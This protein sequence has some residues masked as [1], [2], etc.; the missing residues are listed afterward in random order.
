MLHSDLS[1]HRAEK[2]CGVKCLSTNTDSLH[3]KINEIEPFL[4]IHDIEIAAF[5]ETLPKNSTTEEYKN[6]TLNINGYTC[7]SNFGGRGA[8][9]YISKEFEVIQRYEEHENIFSPSIFCKIKTKSGEMLTIGV[10]YRSPNSSKQE[11]ENF[12]MQLNKVCEKFNTI[13]Q[14]LVLMG[15]FNCPEI[16]WSEET[17]NK[18]S[19][20]IAAKLLD[21]IHLNY[22][23][24]FVDRPTHHRAMQNSTLIDLILSNDPEIV[25]HIKHFPPFGKSHH[26]ALCFSLGLKSSNKDTSHVT[27]YAVNKGDYVNMKEHM[28]GINWVTLLDNQEEVDIMWDRFEAEINKAKELFIP[29]KKFKNSNKHIFQAGSTPLQKLHLKRAAFKTFKK[30][31]TP[32]NYH[33]YTRYRNQ[34]KC[35]ARKAKC[36]KE[37]EVAQFSKSNPKLFF[38][39][40]NSKI[41]PKENISNLLKEDGSLTEGDLEKSEILNNF[42][43]S[44]FTKENT[45]DMPLFICENEVITS[46]VSISMKD[47]EK[48]LLSL[49]TCK[50]PGPDEIHPRILKELAHELSLPLK[51]LFDKTVS[52]GHLPHKWKEAEVRPIYKKGSKTDPGNYRPV[53]LTSVVCKVFEGFVR[54]KIYDHLVDNNLLSDEQYGFC[55]GRS[56]TTQ[57]LN[58]MQD[59]LRQLDN[60]TPVDAVYLDFKK[61]FDTVPHKRLIS[62]LH[63]YGIRGK[64]LDWIKDFLTNR[65]QYVTINKDSSSKIPVT[66]GVPQ[67]SVLGPT[68]F[69]Y[70]INDLP[71]VASSSLK[72]FADDTKAYLPITSTEDKDNLQNTID[73]LV[74]WSNTWL[75]KF[76]SSKCKV[77]HIGKKN[78]KYSYNIREEN[79]LQKL[80]E[81]T[82]EKDLG[83]MVDPLLHFDTHVTGIV[84]RARSLSGLIHKTI[85]FKNKD[86]M[87]PIFKSIIRPTLEYGNVVWHPSNKKYIDLIEGI[88]KHFTRCIVG[89]GGLDYEERLRSLNLPSLEYRRLRGDMIE[90]YKIMHKLYDP[91]TTGSLININN[92]NTRSHNFKLLKPR[93]N[94]KQFQM[95]FTNRVINYWNTLPKEVVNADSLNCFKNKIDD[96]FQEHKFSIKLAV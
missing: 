15:D 4:N 5:V 51:I 45:T 7:L 94:T 66:S 72:I 59:W 86:I 91:K 32:S 61:A 63:G 54:N 14:K 44:V 48:A 47:M 19:N 8:C 95:F 37:K 17:C 93:V 79:T 89:M 74:E 78:P 77:L 11:N 31:P 62:K 75:L 1:I 13:G 68:L 22:L 90:M 40:V 43:A 85:C 28:S 21:N 30:F 53:S 39:Y 23:T 20:H 73:R 96:Y 25:R 35:E 65:S 82:C 83:I 38:Q 64:L 33:L 71:N 52:S 41:K 27:K 58:T 10:I 60:G 57:L 55:P 67:G 80:E 36:Q 87:V 70:Y 56:C 18:P 76:N 81:S 92:T 88:Q 29:K 16:N 9:L 12:I 24:Q 84:K 49:K 42:F 46:E 2:R 3:N 50:S 34:V 26:S 69:I 6:I